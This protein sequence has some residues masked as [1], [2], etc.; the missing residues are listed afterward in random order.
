MYADLDRRE[1]T[2]AA[3]SATIAKQ[4]SVAVVCPFVK[5]LNYHYWRIAPFLSCCKV[6]PR[7]RDAPFCVYNPGELFQLWCEMILAND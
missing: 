3:M 6:R 2:M 4:A 5:T 7:G 1:L